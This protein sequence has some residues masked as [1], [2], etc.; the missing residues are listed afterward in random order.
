MDSSQGI[1]GEDFRG[2]LSSMSGWFDRHGYI[3]ML[4]VLY[5]DLITVPDKLHAA[6]SVMELFELLCTNGHL[7][8]SNLTVL[9]DTI[10]LTKPFGLEPEIR[11]LSMATLF[12]I[13]IINISKFTS[14]R[15]SLIKVVESLSDSDVKKISKLYNCSE[16]ADKWELLVELEQSGNIC[17]ENL[18][19]FMKT[20]TT[21]LI[22]HSNKDPLDLRNKN[23]A[24]REASLRTSTADQLANAI[25]NVIQ[26]S[27]GSARKMAP[28]TI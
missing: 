13:R 21:Y 3:N 7:S 18:D 17:E 24:T 6:T 1:T 27:Q 14:N 25:K 28:I 20:I 8:S 11:K 9:Y 16:D 23:V 22:K 15:Q 4:K 5:R 2:I 26:D 19:D 12:N 10:N